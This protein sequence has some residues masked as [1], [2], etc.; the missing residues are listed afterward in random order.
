MKPFISLGP[1]GR[2]LLGVEKGYRPVGVVVGV[3]VVSMGNQTM[4]GGLDGWESRLVAECTRMALD[5]ALERAR[6]Q[7]KG[8]GGNGVIGAKIAI[9]IDQELGFAEVRCTGTAVEGPPTKD[10]VFLTN[11]DGAGLASLHTAG[12]RVVGLAIGYSFYRQI[13][14]FRSANAYQEARR[15][16]GALGPIVYEHPDYTKATLEARRIAM[17]RLEAD[18]LAV[19]AEGV[20]G[21]ELTNDIKLTGS[22]RDDFLATGTAVRRDPFASLHTS[23]TA[24][25]QSIGKRKIS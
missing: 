21:V 19:S 1:P 14:G 12:Y 20:V 9:K 15:K 25:V 18:A 6:E 5:K 4:T 10:P 13:N 22:L 2:M 11:L 17:Q 8:L 16:A 23:E 24:I 7:A 3:S